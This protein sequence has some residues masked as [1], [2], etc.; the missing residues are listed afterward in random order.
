MRTVDGGQ[1][2]SVPLLDVCAAVRLSE[3]TQPGLDLPQLIRLTTVQS[4]AY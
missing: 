2:L 4:E 3:H 1:D